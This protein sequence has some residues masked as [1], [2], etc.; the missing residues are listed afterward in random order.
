MKLNTLYKLIPMFTEDLTT[1]YLWVNFTEHPVADFQDEESDVYH[2]WYEWFV[3]YGMYFMEEEGKFNQKN[4]CICLLE[5][6]TDFDFSQFSDFMDYQCAQLKKPDEWLKRY[7]LLLFLN[8]DHHS[9]LP[10]KKRLKIIS[11]MITRKQESLNR[12]V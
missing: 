8:E 12:V 9:L 3:E 2:E 11:E 4:Y 10:H 5:T 7:S 6:A 1:G